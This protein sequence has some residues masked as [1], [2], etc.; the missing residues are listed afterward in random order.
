MSSTSPGGGAGI[1]SHAA[2]ETLWQSAGGPAAAADVAAA[3]AQAESGGNPDA[4]SPNPDGGTNVGL[5]QL[6]TRG[7][8]AGHTIAQLRNP[9]TNA[10]LAV[11]GS[12][13]GTDWSAWATYAS[14]AYKAYLT[15]KTTG[16]QTNPPPV[17]SQPTGLAAIGAAVTALGQPNLWL[18][19]GEIILG[20]VL[21]AIGIA[22]VT[23]AVPVATSI[24]RTA[25]AVAL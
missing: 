5:W 2:L 16:V 24:A 7:K 8:G 22:R 13:G 11:A 12:S 4:T 15:G 23:R 21:L 18:R 25:G 3:V 14:G 10:A 19:A 9:G 17:T 20:I 6:D 1:Y